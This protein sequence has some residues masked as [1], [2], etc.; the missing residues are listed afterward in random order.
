MKECQYIEWKEVRNNDCLK[1]IC[2]FANTEGGAL[3]I[4]VNWEVLKED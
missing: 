3:C 1:W 4:G 2:A